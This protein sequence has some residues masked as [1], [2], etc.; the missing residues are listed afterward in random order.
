MPVLQQFST[1]YRHRCYRS[2]YRCLSSSYSNNINILL[3]FNMFDDD[4]DDDDVDV[5]N[6]DCTALSLV[7][8]IPG[9]FVI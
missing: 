9:K 4:D 8:C 3:L 5:S 1:S 6:A 7:Q 2:R